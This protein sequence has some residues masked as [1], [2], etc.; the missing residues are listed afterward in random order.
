MSELLAKIDRNSR[1]VVFYGPGT[2]KAKDQI[3]SLG[4][5]KWLREQK[6]WQIQPFDLSIEELRDYFPNIVIEESGEDT[7]KGNL[8]GELPSSLSVSELIGQI[9]SAIAKA[10]PKTLYIRGVITQVKH[11]QGRVFLGIADSENPNKYVDCVI[12]RDVDKVC[13]SLFSAGFKLEPDLEIMFQVVLQVSHK[14]VRISLNVISVVA[15]YTIARVAA[16]RDVTNERLR[17][18]GLFDANKKLELAF[19]P[20]RLGILTSSA[21]TVINDFRAALDEGQFGFE[22]FWLHVPVQG[23]SAKKAISNGLRKLGRL[24]HCDAIILIRGGGSPSELAVFNE[25][26]IAREICVSP[27]PVISAI[28]HQEDQSSTQDV[29]FLSLGVPKDVG[30]FFA[31]LVLELR[32]QF[33]ESMRCIRQSVFPTLE[34]NESQLK[35][36]EQTIAVIS[37]QVI[38]NRGEALLRAT[39]FLRAV[40][41]RMVDHGQLQITTIINDLMREALRLEENYT[42]RVDRLWDLIQA[43]DP[44]VLLKRGFALIKHNGQYVTGGSELQSGESIEIEFHDISRKAVIE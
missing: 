13:E 34:N 39:D 43:S 9:D 8:T 29:S 11:S 24:K 17:K 1:A 20:R 14:G 31:N 32:A 36:L 33:R 38:L 19:L 28:G 22:L 15:E 2:F 40:G 37:S 6:V 3:K 27:I 10:F 44:R 23:K 18:E 7:S 42:L 25:Y 5:A 12:W 21:G 41:H 35:K 26:E 4:P 30:R 16:L